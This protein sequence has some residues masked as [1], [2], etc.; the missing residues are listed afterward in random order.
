M[1]TGKAFLIKKMQMHINFCSY[2]F[3]FVLNSIFIVTK[4]GILIVRVLE[5]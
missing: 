3:C 1:E 4:S 2:L 5:E